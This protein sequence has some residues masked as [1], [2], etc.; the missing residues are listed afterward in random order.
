L[1]RSA[2]HCG[3]YEEMQN[4]AVATFVLDREALVE[5]FDRART[6]SNLLFDLIEPEA[7]YSR[8]ITL[9]HPIVFY[10]GHLVAFAVNT[11]L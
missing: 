1:Q 11:L 3:E 4:A 8:P 7:Y 2:L 9:R 6:R 10:E 5:R